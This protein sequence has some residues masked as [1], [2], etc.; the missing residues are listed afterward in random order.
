MTNCMAEKKDHPFMQ[1]PWSD[2]LYLVLLGLSVIVGVGIFSGE[3]TLLKNR[4]YG[5]YVVVTGVTEEMVY[6]IT[7]TGKQV[8]INRKEKTMVGQL[9]DIGRVDS[10]GIYD[11]VEVK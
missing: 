8:L 3:L 5:D 7:S 4:E 10:S 6:G 2:T 9:Y 1:F 11:I